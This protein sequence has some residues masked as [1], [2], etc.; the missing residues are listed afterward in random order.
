MFSTVSPYQTQILRGSWLGKT[1][2]CL[3]CPSH[4]RKT[5]GGI[6]VVG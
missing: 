5:L 3:N 2:T 6:P 1:N 4:I